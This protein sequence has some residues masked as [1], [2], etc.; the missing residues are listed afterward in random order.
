MPDA[1]G[2]AFQTEGLIWLVLIVCIAGLVRGFAGFG[3]GMIIMPVASSVLS[4][5]EAVIFLTATELL[6]PLPNLPGAIRDGRAREVGLLLLGAV[7]VLP[8]GIWFLAH[9][10]PELF[11]WFI[12][13]AVLAMLALLISG[14]RFRGR[15]SRPLVIA[16]GGIGGFMTGFA[17]IPGP[18]VIL[19]YMA[20]RLP[21]AVIRANFLLYLLAIDT[22][23]FGVL[24]LN[25]LLNWHIFLLGLLV[26]V[27]NL[28]ANFLGGLMFD[29]KAEGRFR[30]VAYAIIACSALLGL[31]LWKG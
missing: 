15:L 30:A 23:L 28:I 31:P 12:S 20:S 5:V 21:I 16:T 27:P 11:G 17:G 6:G 1:L 14:W 19:L 22:V 24:W 8:L 29:P 7:F 4:P 10:A 25:D 26:G 9:V 13:V 3:S 2:A 18:P